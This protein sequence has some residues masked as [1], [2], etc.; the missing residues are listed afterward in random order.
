MC[1]EGLH[2]MYIHTLIFVR[3]VAPCSCSAT[4]GKFP[5]SETT[6]KRLKAFNCVQKCCGLQQRACGCVCLCIMLHTMY[7]V[8]VHVIC[9]MIYTGAPQGAVFIRPVQCCYKGANLSV[10]NIATA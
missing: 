3:H 9:C 6:A 4:L 2:H 5:F 8:Y 10:V 7:N 1:V